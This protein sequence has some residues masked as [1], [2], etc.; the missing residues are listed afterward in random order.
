MKNPT[1]NPSLG[2]GADQSQMQNVAT[3]TSGNHYHAPDAA[4]LEAAFREI[5]LTLPVVLTE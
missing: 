1:Q 5:A 2:A 3:A 4:A